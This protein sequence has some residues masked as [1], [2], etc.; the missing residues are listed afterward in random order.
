MSGY[1]P[2]SLHTVT[3]RIITEDVSD[4]VAF[5]K[6]VFDGRGEVPAGRPAEIRI[7][8]S[9]VMISDGG[10]VRPP[11][12]AFRYVYVPDADET[13]RRAMAAGATSI[14]APLDT[15]YG[16]R[17]AAIQDPWGNT[18]QIATHRGEG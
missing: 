8:D 4:V 3:P 9:A 18:W 5:L 13:Y 10:G 6:V 14:E 7:G 15:H 2:A 1:Q 17:R 12:A 16:D 11:S